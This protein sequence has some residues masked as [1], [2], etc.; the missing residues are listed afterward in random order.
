M[1]S[2][3][4]YVTSIVPSVLTI[5]GGADVVVPPQQTK[6]FAARARKGWAPMVKI[7]VREGKGHTWG[8]FW[9]LREDVGAFC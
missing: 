1:I 4:Y 2:P 7:I 8:D 5:H 6:S 9:K 3:V